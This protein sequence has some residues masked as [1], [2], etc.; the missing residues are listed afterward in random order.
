MLESFG[1][2]E[3][4]KYAVNFGYM[5]RMKRGVTPLRRTNRRYFLLF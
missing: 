4:N 3:R 2:M 1:Y 5:K